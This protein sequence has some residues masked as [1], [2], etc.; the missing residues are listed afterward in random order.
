MA[1]IITVSTSYW[2][3]VSGV[4][5]LSPKTWDDVE[6]WYIKW[7]ILHVRFEGESKWREFDINSDDSESIDWERPIGADIYAG[8]YECDDELDSSH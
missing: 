1:N 2:C 6:D 3:C 5:D 8:E 4:V 7:D